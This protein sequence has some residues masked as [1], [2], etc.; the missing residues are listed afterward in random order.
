MSDERTSKAVAVKASRVLH[1]PDSSADEKSVAGSA[2]SQAGDHIEA[3]EQQP[4]V[5]EVVDSKTV[6]L[7]FAPGKPEAGTHP[8]TGAPLPSP[9]AVELGHGE[10]SRRFVASDQPFKVEAIEEAPFLLGT[11]LFVEAPAE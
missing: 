1:D 8:T 3:T 5:A 10:Y 9:S 2:L 6:L 11:G 7:Q 4:P